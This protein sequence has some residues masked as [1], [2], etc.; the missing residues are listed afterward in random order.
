MSMFKS[1][2]IMLFVSITTAAYSAG[3]PAPTSRKLMSPPMLF[4]DGVITGRSIDP[5]VSYLD[6]LTKKERVPEQIDLVINSPGGSVIAG[7][8]FLNRMSALRDRGTTFNCYVLDVAA[9]MAFQILTQ[10]DS[11]SAL[12]TSFLLW[13]GVRVGS[14]DVTAKSALSLSRDLARMDELILFQLDQS[15]DLSADSIRFHFDQETLWSG[16]SLHTRD[17]SFL[18]LG[19]SA[20]ILRR[21]G[22]PKTVTTAPA[23]LFDQLGGFIYQWEGYQQ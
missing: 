23:S 21:I 8:F 18:D 6:T 11:R 14:A 4:L 7:M 19:Y 5:L 13:H 12:P 22:D 1:F 10:C 17:P 9:S 16:L 3:Q 15:L 20:D 2:I